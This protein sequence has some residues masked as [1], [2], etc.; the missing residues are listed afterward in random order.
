[1]N[2]GDTKG[3]LDVELYDGSGEPTSLWMLAL[4]E[5]VWGKENW[6]RE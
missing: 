4:S 3:H 6:A 2:I 1:V 5:R